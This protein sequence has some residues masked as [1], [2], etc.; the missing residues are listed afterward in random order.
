MLNTLPAQNGLLARASMEYVRHKLHVIVLWA[1][2][3]NTSL[4]YTLWM[5]LREKLVDESCTIVGII[6]CRKINSL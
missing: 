1:F 3:E 6:Q 4:Y 5:S 2:E